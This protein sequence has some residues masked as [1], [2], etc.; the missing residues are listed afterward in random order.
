[1]VHR[2]REAIDG[3]NSFII[4]ERDQSQQAQTLALELPENNMEYHDQPPTLSVARTSRRVRKVSCYTYSRPRRL[5]AMDV[6]KRLVDFF[7]KKSRRG[8]CK[9]RFGPKGETR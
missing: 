2:C 8:K 5:G 9:S 4:N 7:L 6:F 3:I 1:M